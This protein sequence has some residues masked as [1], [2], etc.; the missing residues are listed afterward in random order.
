MIYVGLLCETVT[1]K[2]HFTQVV[3]TNLK[4]AF[5]KRCSDYYRAI[6][7]TGKHSAT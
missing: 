3:D 7:S 5:E 1:V 4:V 6:K 2:F